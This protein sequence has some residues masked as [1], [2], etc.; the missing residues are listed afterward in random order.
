MNIEDLKI[1]QKNFKG[2]IYFD[3]NLSKLNWF[4]IGGNTKIFFKPDNLEDLILFL[5]IYNQR[6]KIFII[7]A[8]SNILFKDQSYN[9][10]VIKLTKKFSN[11]SLL[12]ENIIVAGS[13]VMDKAISEFAMNN[14]IG[15]LEFLSCIPGTIG[16]GI[17]MNTGCFGREIKD[18]LISVQVLDKSGKV[19]TI[20]SNEIKFEY[21]KCNLPND[22]IFLSASFK[23]EYKEKAKIKQEISYL[24]NKKEKSQPSKIKTGGSTF[25]NPIGASQVKVWELIKKSVPENLSFGDATISSKHSNF[26]VNKG[27]ATYKDMKKLIDFI[28]EKVKAKTGIKIDLEII[29]VE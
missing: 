7:G 27:N 23:G 24:K 2:K 12:N 20:P 13:A 3:Y 15:G 1:N 8:G 21:R 19:R 4:N 6:G 16:G 18:I 11:I 10:A 22:F 26:L 14:N 17:R 9:G 28:I 29:I 5:N 25:K